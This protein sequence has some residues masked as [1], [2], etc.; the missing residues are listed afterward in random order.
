MKLIWKLVRTGKHYERIIQLLKLFCLEKLYLM[1]VNLTKV[2]H[3]VLQILEKMKQKMDRCLIKKYNAFD[4][5][6]WSYIEQF[7]YENLLDVV[8]RRK[9]NSL[10]EC[11]RRNSKNLNLQLIRIYLDILEL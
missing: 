11:G 10:D 8:I 7:H 9:L 1:K 2:H 4:V 5:M 6:D 3:L